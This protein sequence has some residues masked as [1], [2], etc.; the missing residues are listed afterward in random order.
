MPG[1]NPHIHRREREREREGEG[2]RGTQNSQRKTNKGKNVG[3][4]T[5]LVHTRPKTNDT[6]R[7]RSLA[8]GRGDF[9]SVPMYELYIYIY[10]YIY[11]YIDL[12]LLVYPSISYFCRYISV[13][14]CVY[15]YICTD[16]SISICIYTI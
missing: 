16:V 12:R 9:F 10:M 1:F 11:M 15:V 2:D 7:F 4:W 14:A 8:C 13:H 5:L 6:A 3:G